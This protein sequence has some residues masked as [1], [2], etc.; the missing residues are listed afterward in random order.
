MVFLINFIVLAWNPPT[1]PPPEENVPPPL[2]ISPIGQTKTGALIVTTLTTSAGKLYLD[3]TTEGD[4]ERVDRVIGYNDLRLWGNPA[5]TTTIYLDSPTTVTQ[6][7]TAQSGITLGGVRRTTWPA[8]GD[9]TAVNAGTGLTGGGPEGD[10]TLSANT[11]YL[12]RRVSGTCGA[13]SSIRVINADGTVTC[14][15][16]DGGGVTACSDCDDRF[17]NQWETWNSDLTV[18]GT[19]TIGSYGDIYSDSSWLRL[20]QNHTQNIYT[21]RIMRADG[22]FQVDGYEMVGSN[23]DKLYANRKNTSGGGIWISD[24]GGFYD[25]NN[26]YVDFRGSTGIRVLE[27]NGTWGDNS[28]RATNLCMKNDCRNTWPSGTLSGSG[29]TNYLSKWTG[30]TSLGNSQVYDNGTNVGIGTTGPATNLHIEGSTTQLLRINSTSGQPGIQLVT[31]GAYSPFINFGDNGVIGESSIYHA[32][33]DNSLRFRTGGSTDRV[34]IDS[35]GN[36]GIGTTGPNSKLHVSGGTGSVDVLIEADTDNVGEGDQPSITLSQ[37]GGAVEGKLGYF[38]STNKL[39]L[40]NVY[41]DALHLGTN[42]TN[43]LT[44]LGNGNVGIGTTGPGYKLDVA[45]TA[46]VQGA[47]LVPWSSLCVKGGV[48]CTRS[49]S[50]NAP[51]FVYGGIEMG[52][53]RLWEAGAYPNTSYYANDNFIIFRHRGQSEDFIGYRNNKFYFADASGGEDGSHPWVGLGS[54]YGTISSLE[55]KKDITK[56][57]NSDYQDILGKITALDVVHFRFKDSSDDKLHLGFVIEE[58]PEEIVANDNPQFL[59]GTDLDA[60]TVAGVKALIQEN[61]GL[62]ERVNGLEE[63]IQKLEVLLSNQ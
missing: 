49:R 13:G 60:F 35:S 23:A 26:G 32:H 29:S 6:D 30:S 24:D 39:T 34:T 25:Y 47:L 43:R 48:D 38:D 40:K 57:S 46:Q 58:A 15:I 1:A 28:I 11:T 7:L 63:R 14:E 2:N 37:D 55:Y 31:G 9:I 61:D 18:A 59:S 20:N 36:V 16:D 17:V 41:N 54:G 33:G 44:I 27:T 5:R 45:G 4:I 42:N 56:L 22:G 62:K 50:T 21:P 51:L 53:G 3:D 52:T 12:Q 19:L 8:G 10:V